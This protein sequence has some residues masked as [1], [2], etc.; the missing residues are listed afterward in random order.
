M[1][2]EN[3]HA[4]CLLRNFNTRFSRKFVKLG[5]P[6]Q[7]DVAE[8]GYVMLP[9]YLVLDRPPPIAR[10]MKLDNFILEV[11][12]GNKQTLAEAADLRT[13]ISNKI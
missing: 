5:Y 11:C 7:G 10:K 3:Y 1:V 13:E 8:G 6:S 4:D 12:N 9:W 2:S